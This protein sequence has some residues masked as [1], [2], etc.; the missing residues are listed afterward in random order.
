M[1][2]YDAFGGAPDL[3]HGVDGSGSG[4]AALLEL[5]RLFSLLYVDLSSPG[6]YNLLFVLTG[7][8]RI[9]YL[10]AKHFVADAD[11]ASF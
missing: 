3:A 11:P 1:A 8:G 5:A 6:R 4:V 9:N 10:G 2:H 7:A